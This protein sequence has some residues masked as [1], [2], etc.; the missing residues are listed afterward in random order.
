MS[1]TRWPHRV[2][3]P[4]D[5]DA[6]LDYKIDWSDWLV[7]GETIVDSEWLVE[8]VTVVSDAFS[9]S[10]TTV[11]VS[12]ATANSFSLTNRITTNSV[13]VARVDDRTLIIKVAS[14]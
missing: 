4:F 1:I 8:G 10:D 11:W 13:P 12:E 14:R 2:P 7:A 3:D 9:P 6:V 5:P